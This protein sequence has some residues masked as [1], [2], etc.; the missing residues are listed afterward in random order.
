[1]QCF[2][3]RWG[4][5]SAEKNDWKSTCISFL[6]LLRICSCFSFRQRK[7]ICVFIDCTLIFIP[8]L[9][10]K[11]PC[12]R[13]RIKIFKLRGYHTF[14]FY[15]FASQTHCTLQFFYVWIQTMAMM[16]LYWI[17]FSCFTK[18]PLHRVQCNLKIS[19]KNVGSQ[20]F[21][22]VMVMKP[23]TWQW[24]SYSAISS[25]PGLGIWFIKDIFCLWFPM[26]LNQLVICLA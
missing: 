16:Y 22:H 23:V 12:Q 6:S 1:M 17:M 20:H 8:R 18:G 7:R 13:M 25:S 26:T 10:K 21:P 19:S 24:L 14:F 3:E 5:G 2:S 4:R 9:H 11:Q 15:C